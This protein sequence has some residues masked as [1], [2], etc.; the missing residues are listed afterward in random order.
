MYE[1]CMKTW[2]LRH[3]ERTT[4]HSGAEVAANSLP[5]LTTCGDLSQVNSN[6]APFS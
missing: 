1:E 2:I 4:Q 5:E 6:L 3:A